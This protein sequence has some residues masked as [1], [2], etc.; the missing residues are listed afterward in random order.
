M[1]VSFEEL[2]AE[3]KRVFVKYGMPEDKA[4]IC[5]QIHTESTYDGIYSHGVN[6]VARFADYLQKGWVD[7]LADPTVEKDLGAIQVINGNLGPGITNALFG[8]AHAMALADQ[9][10]IGL[11][12]QRLRHRVG[13]AQILFLRLKALEEG[14]VKRCAA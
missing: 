8:A 9:Y 13:I 7:P 14:A 6:R 4:D 10:G 3:I 12:A 1:R 2:K 5:A 11:V